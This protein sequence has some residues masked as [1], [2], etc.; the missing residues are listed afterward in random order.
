MKTNEQMLEDLIKR[1]EIY[2]K[3]QAVKRRRFAVISATLAIILIVSSIP[4]IAFAAA[5]KNTPDLPKVTDEVVTE[6][7]VMTNEN[8]DFNDVTSVITV[9]DGSTESE[10]VN[11]TEKQTDVS[12]T[13][14][15]DN[16]TNHTG[17]PQKYFFDADF[18]LV[19]S[20]NLIALSK[21]YGSKNWMNWKVMKDYELYDCYNGDP[22]NNDKVYYGKESENGIYS[23]LITITINGMLKEITG[24]EMVLYIETDGSSEIISGN[25]ACFSS[26]D[27][28]SV[29]D[30]RYRITFPISLKLNGNIK[31]TICKCYTVVPQMIDEN[32]KLKEHYKTG[33]P[34]AEFC[35][36][37]IHGYGF[38]ENTNRGFYSIRTLFERASVYFGDVD[39]NGVPLFISDP[40]LPDYQHPQCKIDRSRIGDIITYSASGDKSKSIN[41]TKGGV[42]QNYYISVS[43]YIKWSIDEDE[44]YGTDDG[45]RF[46]KDLKI[47]FFNDTDSSLLY[48]TQQ[49]GNELN[50]SFAVPTISPL[51]L[52]IEVWLDSDNINVTD[53][54]STVHKIIRLIEDVP[55]IASYNINYN[56]INSTDTTTD[57]LNR[58]V[59][60]HQS[61]IMANK[62]IQSLTGSMLDEIEVRLNENDFTYYDD[63]FLN[64][65]ADKAIYVLYRDAFDWDVSQHEFGHYVQDV[66]KVSGEDA[67]G[68]HY[69]TKDLLSP[70]Y[71]YSKKKAIELAWSEGWADFFPINLQR[72]M[73]AVSYNIP[74]VGD[75]CYS[76]FEEPVEFY[77]ITYIDYNI[78]FDIETLDDYM[79]WET[80]SLCETNEITIAAL[81]L[82]FVDG[83]SY[84]DLDIT[85]FSDSIIWNI[86]VGD[87]TDPDDGCKSLSDFMIAFH[88]STEL[89]GTQKLMCMYLLRR[90]ELNPYDVSVTN[91]NLGSPHVS[92]TNIST[93]TH[94]MIRFFDTSYNE[95][96]TPIFV[97]YQ[98]SYDIPAATWAQ[99]ISGRSSVIIVVEGIAGDYPMTGRYFSTTVGVQI[100]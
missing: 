6:D 81:L 39:G 98:T 35:F 76:D 7:Y 79:N 43:G 21:E 100:P 44:I 27:Y 88:S 42:I 90:Y 10:S 5:N 41:S 15:V 71:S 62:Y 47:K 13:E 58:A 51:D 93:H 73:N 45:L 72:V 36:I 11:I 67:N 92:W 19:G 89:S 57:N 33:D 23:V 25:Y 69:L 54:G 8:D 64:G 46:A 56:F 87:E 63:D 38:V 65:G 1:K 24:E 70:P 91:V 37:D 17:K 55:N 60:V 95:I 48:Q 31:Y 30:D 32:G 96:Y 50:A 77:G 34:A 40:T 20:G 86:I 83:V 26:D 85:Q 12:S 22:D 75:S 78:D 59:S 80:V 68:S 3:R 82:D 97:S 4:L 74:Y 28:K 94:N 16:E 18:D 52:R 2:D 84:T 29:T 53:D 14:T 61:L 99:I 66:Y 9:D 49:V